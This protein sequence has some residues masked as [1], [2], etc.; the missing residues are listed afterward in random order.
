[1]PGGDDAD[2]SFFDDIL[3]LAV[4]SIRPTDIHSTSIHLP[5]AFG[6]QSDYLST[7][8]MVLE[9]TM[10]VVDNSEASRNGDYL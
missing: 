9:A 4:H 10:I 2:T 3:F 7:A 1:L 8:T 5:T 6:T